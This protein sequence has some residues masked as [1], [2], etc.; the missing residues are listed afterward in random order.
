MKSTHF[1]RINN[2]I[3]VSIFFVLLPENLIEYEFTELVSG[4]HK[5]ALCIDQDE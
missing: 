3:S 2:I 1:S 5:I 4:V